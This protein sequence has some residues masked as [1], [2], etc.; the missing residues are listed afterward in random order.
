MKPLPAV[1][2]APA[3]RSTRGHGP[4]D[5]VTALIEGPAPDGGLYL[6]TFL[7]RLAEART[8][9]YGA[10]S[11]SR[12][13]SSPTDLARA[14]EQVLGGFLAPHLSPDETRDLLADALDFPAPL[15]QLDDDTFVLELS[16]GP[17][18]AFKDVGARVLAYLLARLAPPTEGGTRTVLVATSGDTGGAVARAFQGVEGFRVYVLYPRWGVSDVQRRLFTAAGGNV[19]AVAVEGTFDDCQALA[20]DAFARAEVRAAHGLTAANSLNV[21]RLLPQMA[22]YALA[23]GRLIEAGGTPPLFVVPSGNL[24]NLTAG[25]LAARMGV[26]AAGFVAALNV[27]DA[28]ARY[29][30]GG[31]AET[32]APTVSTLSSAMDVG[33]PSNLERLAALTGHDP[34]ALAR[35]VTAYTVNDAD[36]RHTMKRVAEWHG[37]LI[38]PHTAVALAA[39]ERLR[40]R[41][42]AAGG[43][44]V[45]GPDGGVSPR[46]AS[47]TAGPAVV[48]STAHPGK[49]PDLVRDATGVAPPPPPGMADLADSSRAER[50]D[51]IPPR[52]DALVAVLEA[53]GSGGERG[54][55]GDA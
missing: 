4:V 49:F 13:S 53:A 45:G 8:A 40:A 29:L 7:P 39:V 21:G 2:R 32:D 37:C 48:L 9:L 6:P 14:A 24:G 18:G 27:N 25:L 52:L 34:A 38:D 33:R 15:V 43:G 1:T 11:A 36:T 3:F 51:V 5:L 19:R 10:T 42:P 41:P 31:P 55:E 12:P 30:A 54:K 35:E 50:Y 28:F 23:A 16:H 20:R 26:P 17:S 46:R 22:Y 44:P 47:P